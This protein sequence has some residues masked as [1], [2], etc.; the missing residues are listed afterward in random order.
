MPW[1]DLIRIKETKCNIIKSRKYAVKSYVV[2]RALVRMCNISHSLVF[3]IKMRNLI[4]REVFI[5]CKPSS[6]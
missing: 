5:P 6:Q 4:K 2:T 1:H 3:L